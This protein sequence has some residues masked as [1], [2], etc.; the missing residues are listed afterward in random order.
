[1]WLVE[2][3]FHEMCWRAVASKMEWSGMAA[4]CD[5]MHFL[6]TS[7]WLSWKINVQMFREALLSCLLHV[8]GVPLAIWS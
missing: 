4:C 1:M 8:D 3:S 6:I 2:F 7:I 5:A